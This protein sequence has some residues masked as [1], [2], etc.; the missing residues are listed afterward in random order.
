MGDGFREIVYAHVIVS[1]ETVINYDAISKDNDDAAYDY[2]ALVISVYTAV[3]SA[4]VC[5]V[6]YYG[7]GVV[8]DEA[9]GVVGCLVNDERPMTN[10]LNVKGN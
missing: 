7:S 9:V 6:S 5:V 10:A 1:N 2:Y 8:Y 4:D 3:I